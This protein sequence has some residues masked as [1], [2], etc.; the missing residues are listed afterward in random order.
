M[1]YG[2]V[3][4]LGAQFYQ[5]T[6]SLDAGYILKPMQF[7]LTIPY[8]VQ[9][10]TSNGVQADSGVVEADILHTLQ[11][12]GMFG[13]NDPLK[14]I[15]AA[16]IKELVWHEDAFAIGFNFGLFTSLVKLDMSVEKPGGYRNGSFMSSTNALLLLEELN[17]RNNLLARN[18][19]NGN[20]TT[21][22]LSWQAR[23]KSLDVQ[24]TGI[25]RLRL[26]TGAPIVRLCLPN[27]LEEL[28]LE[29]LTKLPESG[30]VLE[31]INNITGYRFVGCPGI[32]G[33]SFARKTSCGQKSRYGKIGTFQY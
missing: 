32:D 20:V 6:A 1:E 25:T 9:L 18:G 33:F 7:A 21:L 13:E 31:G 15:G 5:S 28:F 24:G 2:Y 12:K 22:D 16:K 23:L 30:L 3:S 19:D 26:A 10:S 8:R 29:Y 14:I 11:L 27:T 17:M 4:T